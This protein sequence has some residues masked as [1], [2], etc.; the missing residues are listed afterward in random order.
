MAKIALAVAKDV[1]IVILTT[2]V[3]Y[4]VNPLREVNVNFVNRDT[5]ETTVV[6]YISE[7]VLSFKVSYLAKSGGK[8]QIYDKHIPLSLYKSKYT[9]LQMSV[10]LSVHL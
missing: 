7:L 2:G 5:R 8:L 3:F 10:S 6:K 1:W 9:V 4:V